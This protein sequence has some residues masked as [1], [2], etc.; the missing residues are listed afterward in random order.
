MDRSSAS[1]ITPSCLSRPPP[2]APSRLRAVLSLS[3]ALLGCVDLFFLKPLPHFLQRLREVARQSL[4]R[5]PVLGAEGAPQGESRVKRPAAVGDGVRHRL[6]LL[7]HHLGDEFPRLVELRLFL[8]HCF[9][10]FCSSSRL[11][12]CLQSLHLS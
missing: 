12:S 7:T 3:P 4:Y 9:P 1:S 5:H 11:R 10:P 8:A 2:D 6:L